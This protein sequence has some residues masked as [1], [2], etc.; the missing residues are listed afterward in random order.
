MQRC[1]PGS[2]V[3]PWPTMGFLGF[4][5]EAANS[6]QLPLLK[7]SNSIPP[8]PTLHT[9]HPYEYKS[10][11]PFAHTYLLAMN[12]ASVSWAGLLKKAER[13][14]VRRSHTHVTSS[15]APCLP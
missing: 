5:T 11:P 3:P 7:D 12:G 4:Q 1:L 15:P 2:S 6:A 14:R 8:A 13:Q 9:F 10:F